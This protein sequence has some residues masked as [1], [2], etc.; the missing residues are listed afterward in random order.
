[1]RRT[2]RWSTATLIAII[3]FLIGTPDALAFRTLAADPTLQ[4]TTPPRW[5]L[6]AIHFDVFA[7]SPAVAAAL[8]QAGLDA[9]AAWAA[10]QCGGGAALSCGVGPGTAASGGGRNTNSAL[11]CAWA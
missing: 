3:A 2:E 9:S 11:P 8:E 1:M 10:P 6:G 7:D 4:T 5:A